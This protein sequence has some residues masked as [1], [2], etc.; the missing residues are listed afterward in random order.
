MDYLILNIRKTRIDG[1]PMLAFRA[2]VQ[3][4]GA[5]VFRG[6]F[7]APAKTPRS[8]LHTIPAKLDAGLLT[9]NARS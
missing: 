4:G 7:T 3:V 6:H 2:M 5:W 9:T 8:L 1:R